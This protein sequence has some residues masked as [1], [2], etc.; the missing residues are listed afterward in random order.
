MDSP[1][2]YALERLVENLALRAGVLGGTHAPRSFHKAA[3]YD[4]VWW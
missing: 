1:L 2:E 4:D 3:L